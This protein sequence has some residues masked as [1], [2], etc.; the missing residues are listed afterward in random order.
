MRDGRIFLVI[1]YA[2]GVASF[3]AARA[4]VPVSEPWL[5]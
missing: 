4:T 1:L 3:S 5:R 2:D